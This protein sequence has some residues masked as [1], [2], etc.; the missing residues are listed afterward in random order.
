MLSKL[1]FRLLQNF[2]TA[3]KCKVFFQHTKNA[4]KNFKYTATWPALLFIDVVKNDSDWK[5]LSIYDRF[6]FICYEKRFSNNIK[7]LDLEPKTVSEKI[8]NDIKECMLVPLVRELF[9]PPNSNIEDFIKMF[10]CPF[11]CFSFIL[12]EKPGLLSMFLYLFLSFFSSIGLF[13]AG[14]FEICLGMI[15]K[16]LRILFF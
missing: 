12:P 5:K 7:S 1:S 9:V 3:P 10:L 8:A 2:K 11:C 4:A 6:Q 16:I 13:V 15:F 14:V